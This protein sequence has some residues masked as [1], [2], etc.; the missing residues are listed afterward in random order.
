M[1]LQADDSAPIQRCHS[2]HRYRCH[3]GAT[4]PQ[5][6]CR[7]PQRVVQPPLRMPGTR[8]LPLPPSCRCWRVHPEAGK[9]SAADVASPSDPHTHSQTD[10][11]C[12]SGC[13]LQSGER[14]GDD[15]SRSQSTRLHGE[16]SRCERPK[17][18]PTQKEGI[19]THTLSLSLMPAS[20]RRSHIKT[21]CTHTLSHKQTHRK[22]P[23]SS[24]PHKHIASLLSPNPRSS[25][26]D[27][28]AV[29]ISPREQ[30]STN[31]A[32]IHCERQ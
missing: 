12:S 5:I 31:W 7:F 2:L 18:T 4:C 8:V 3:C 22:G 10:F 11:A 16:Q 28:R 1:G 20:T 32:G 19:H 29:L 14:D 6:H 15:R 27:M 17:H 9:Y 21:E 26:A 24:T 30:R 13:V 25:L 23:H